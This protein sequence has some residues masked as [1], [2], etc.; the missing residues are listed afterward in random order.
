MT[1]DRIAR[2]KEFHCD[3]AALESDLQR[4][5]D[6]PGGSSFVRLRV[7][8]GD[9]P[10]L[11]LSDQIAQACG[12]RSRIEEVWMIQDVISF[13]A[14]FGLNAFGY[15]HPLCQGYVPVPEAWPIPLVADIVRRRAPR[16]IGKGA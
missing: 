3:N 10:K 14:Q 11:R 2:P 6:L 8:T 16:R 7:S 12:V 5:L 9:N 15:S 4:H 13:E 1:R